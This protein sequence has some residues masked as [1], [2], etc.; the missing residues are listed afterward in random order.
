MQRAFGR[1]LQ[2]AASQGHELKEKLSALKAQRTATGEIIRAYQEQEMS[3]KQARKRL[4][5]IVRDQVEMQAESA[6]TQIVVLEQFLEE[7]EE[8]KR[9]PESATQKRIDRL[10]MGRGQG[11]LLDR[12]M[13]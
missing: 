1:A 7:L 10:M 5:P 12:L 9:D 11:G 8:V 13:P 3:A 2:K 6:H 4:Y